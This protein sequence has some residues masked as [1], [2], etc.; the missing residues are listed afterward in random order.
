MGALPAPEAPGHEHEEDDRAL[1]VAARL[2]RWLDGRFVDPLLG[3]LLPGVGDLL[4]SAL[5]LY[6]V[7]LAWRRRGVD[8]ALLVSIGGALI[9][10]LLWNAATH[11]RQPEVSVI[12]RSAHELVTHHSPYETAAA[13]AT[14]HNPNAFNPYLPVMSLF[15]VPR[16]E[17]GSATIGLAPR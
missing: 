9:T 3:L 12:Q 1:A 7:L 5:G 8:L 6:P 15:G 17:F 14:T 11:R 10:P 4:G 13:L 16:A 2:A